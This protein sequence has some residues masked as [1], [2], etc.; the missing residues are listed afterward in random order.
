MERKV[1]GHITKLGPRRAND[2]PHDPKEPSPLSEQQDTTFRPVNGTTYSD[3]KQIW[4]DRFDKGFAAL[5]EQL[6]SQWDR[7]TV[8]LAEAFGDESPIAGGAW[9]LAESILSR[10]FDDLEQVAG[11]CGSPIEKAMLMALLTTAVQRGEGARVGNLIVGNDVGPESLHITPQFKVGRFRVDF[12]VELIYRNGFEDGGTERY[13]VLVECD[14]HD[15]HEKT[16]DQAKRDKV[17][18]RKLQAAGHT[19]MHYT[20]SEI[21]N[22]PFAP[23]LEVYDFLTGKAHETWERRKVGL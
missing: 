9:S 5:S 10:M 18:D 23:A 16:R 4:Q 11:E 15:F 1:T 12:Q 21:W 7:G 3:G 19:V 14:G 8:V 20:G 17:R 22:D 13:A 6:D 2:R